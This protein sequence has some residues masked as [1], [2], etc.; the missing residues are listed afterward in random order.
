MSEGKNVLKA[1]AA[2]ALSALLLAGCHAAPAPDDAPPPPPDFAP[3]PPDPCGARA[4][5]SLTGQSLDDDTR[6]WLEDRSRAS[7]IRI[8]EPGHSYTTDH[9]PERLQ[10]VVDED[11]TITSISCG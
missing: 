3:A 10:V 4:V 11:E 1:G 8:V 5:G 7:T 2:M 9:L 6:T